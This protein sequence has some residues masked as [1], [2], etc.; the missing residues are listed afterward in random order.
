MYYFVW[1]LKLVVQF[2]LW[3]R[4][5]SLELLMLYWKMCMFLWLEKYILEQL[6]L[7]VICLGVCIVLEGMMILM[8]LLFKLYDMML[9]L[10]LLGIFMLFQIILFFD[11][12]RVILFG[13]GWWFIMVWRGVWLF[14]LFM[15]IWLCW[16]I[17]F[18]VL[19]RLRL[20][21]Y[22]VGVC[23]LLQGVCCW[24]VVLVV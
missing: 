6:L 11:G 5:F 10:F 18:G 7:I 14:V 19:L 8:L 17:F 23:R 22:K 16:Y 15:R 2:L 20:R 13:M 24:L 1:L 9:L 21:M 3:M 12:Q 4:I